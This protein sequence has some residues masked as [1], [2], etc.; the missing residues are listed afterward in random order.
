LNFPGTFLLI[1]VGMPEGWFGV[2]SEVSNFSWCVSR[3]IFEKV[4]C[5]NFIAKTVSV[6]EQQI[7]LG[8]EFRIVS[9]L[10]IQLLSL[11]ERSI[12]LTLS[13]NSSWRVSRFSNSPN[14][15]VRNQSLTRCA[16]LLLSKGVTVQAYPSTQ[17]PLSLVQ[18]VSVWRSCQG[19]AFKFVWF[20]FYVCN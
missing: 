19:Q 5:F 2:K 7:C 10:M 4:F 20:V 3:N 12:L 13:A 17:Q 8:S 14:R 1:P 9:G 16:T 18:L 15:Y 11:A 6:C